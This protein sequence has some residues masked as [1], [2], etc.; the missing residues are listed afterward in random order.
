MSQKKCVYKG[1]MIA[2]LAAVA[3]LALIAGFAIGWAWDKRPSSLLDVSILS[4]MTAIGTVG[5]TCVG[6]W[7]ALYSMSS[8][9]LRSK[10]AAWGVLRLTARRCQLIKRQL[11]TARQY[12]NIR[13]NAEALDLSMGHVFQTMTLYLDDDSTMEQD[14]ALLA[15]SPRASEALDRARDAAGLI[16]SHY[17]QSGWTADGSAGR[18]VSVRFFNEVSDHIE[19]FQLAADQLQECYRVVTDSLGRSR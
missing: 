16:K 8:S 1:K 13:G 14:I 6:V 7:G 4:V 17:Y 19:D 10:R 12:A 15:Y 3:L 18:E 11:A 9:S 2:A 5:A